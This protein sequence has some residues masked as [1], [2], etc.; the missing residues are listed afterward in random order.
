MIIVQSLALS[1]INY[2]SR[3]WGITT[4]EQLDRVQKV[5]NFAAKVAF[6]GAR[7]Y[8]HVTPILKELQWMDIKSKIT[9]D[10]CTFTFKV[11]S[12]MLPDWLFS[13]PSVGELQARPTRQAN[14]LAI[15]RTNTNLASRAITIKGPKEWNDLPFSIR[16]AASIKVFE[17]N[18]RKY[19]LENN[20]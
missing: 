17:K 20:F 9:F 10:I 12:N 19:I 8:D 14:R 3:I 4:R 18:L 11:I 5:Q 15:K 13:F 7:K 1:I 6:G 16:N 2:S